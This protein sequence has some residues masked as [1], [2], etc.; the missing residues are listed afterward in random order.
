MR[1]TTEVLVRPEM[2]PDGRT[3]FY[4]RSN[5]PRSKTSRLIARDLE[6]G[7]EKELFQIVSPARLT[8][9]ALAPDGERFVLSIIPDPTRPFA[10]VLKILSVANG[11]PRELIQF[12][13]S[14][15]LRAVGVTW[16][17]DSGS[18]LFWKWKFEADK[19]LELW[20]ISAAG[21]EP[22]KLCSR[23]SFGNMRIH[24]DGKRIAFYDR[25]TTR[26]LWVMEN[27]LPRA[28]AAAE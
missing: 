1:S 25:S 13:K 6:S 7:H 12:D 28:V 14:E 24:P 27:F 15:N 20:R 9:R 16:T 18:V 4:E 3:L 2:S 8:N 17:P 22:R 19:E 23:K 10:P 21:G 26:E 11:E 5:D